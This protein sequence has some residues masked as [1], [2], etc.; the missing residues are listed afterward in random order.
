MAS[1]SLNRVSTLVESQLP[2]FIRSD[3]PVFVEF[4]EKYYEFLEQPGK[5]IY[6]LKRFPDNYNID[7]ARENLLNYFREKI[8][9]SF[10]E[11]SQLSTERIIKSARDFYAKKGTPESFQFL[12][13]VLYDKDLEIYFPKLQILKAS[14]GKWV[15]PQAFRLTLSAV[16]TSLNLDLIEKKKAFGSLSRATCVV[17]RAFRTL[18]KG[19]NTEIVEIYV[20]SVNRL[21]QNGEYLEIQYIDESGDPQI[22]SEKIIGAISNIRINPRRRGTRYVTGDPVVING[23]L[24]ITS[25]TRQK[26][27]ALVGNVTTGSID[28]ISILKKGYGFRAFP[29]SLVDIITANGVGANVIV[30]ALDI[31]NVISIPYCTDSIL[32]K[33]NLEIGN[34]DFD[35][36]NVILSYANTAG[37]GNSTTTVNI[38]NIAG[39]IASAVDDYYN[40]KLL[41]IISGTGAAGSP[42]SAT[43][44]DY[45]GTTKI[46]TL[47][48][49]LAIAPDATSNVTITA[50]ANTTLGTAFSYETLNLSPLLS[51][52]TL[53]GGSNFDAEPTL[54]VIAVYDSDW[55]T[56][57]GFEIISPGEF[58]TYNPSN[59]SIKFAGS[60]FSSNDG[61]YVGRR[62]FVEKHFRTIIG[63][64]GAT[65][66]AFL[67][68]PFEINITSS[69]SGSI[70]TKT[71]RL[72][73][74]PTIQ[75][76]GRIAAIEIIN[77]GTGYVAGDALSFIGTGYGAAATV[78]TVDPNGA[79]T[80][81]T[82]SDRGEGYPAAPTISLS[83]AGSRTGAVLQAVL[84]SDGEEFD[85]VTGDIGQI[86]DFTLLSR[87]S[88]YIITPNVS[89]KIYDLLLNTP[90]EGVI[91]SEDDIV[92]QGANVNITTFRATVD[93]YISSNNILRVFNYSGA[94]IVGSNLVLYKA[95]SSQT[96]LTMVSSTVGGKTYPYRVGNGKA[97][98]NAEFLNGLIRY[99]GF[100]LNTDGHLSSDKK[101][102]DDEKYHN[103]S[104]SLV[105][106]ESL[107]NYKKTIL[108]VSHPAGT[109]LLATHVIPDSY[110]VNETININTHTLILT[111]N[112]LI[113]S[114]NIAYGSNQVTNSNGTVVEY[115]DTVANVGDIIIINSANSL[116]TF[117]K[118]ITEIANNNSLNIESP[119]ILIGE[120][121]A[122]TNATNAVIEISGNT[123]IL[124][125]F[126][127]TGDRIQINV[128]GSVLTK[129]INSIS[130]NTITLN[131]N[132]G[133]TS[134]N[135]N[136][137]YLVI[138]Q[139][140]VVPYEIIKT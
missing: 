77:G 58:N 62:L 5:P 126:I 66:T 65:K 33:A 46:A 50:N 106:E 125:A 47:A 64:D 128:G 71:L 131:S 52:T 75:G 108:D 49:A 137:I 23:G 97:R 13:R 25:A 100:Y 91:I 16:N 114:C 115:F 14:D 36:D 4:L 30:S 82:I 72:D 136:L 76:M 26:A 135:T 98:A 94:P 104:Y 51:M 103:Y 3:Y 2:E 74:R 118:V 80:S 38:A 17:E 102:Q 132:T 139:F 83:T 127:D 140:N 57:Q 35:F 116:R 129:T 61:W 109:K 48:S 12:F 79:I 28:S 68:R 41:T 32:F 121:R 1:S 86:R 34:S 84:F 95:D 112:S 67:D 134:S 24:D 20:S 117:A 99:N 31:A 87:G 53:S 133:I 69:G 107:T 54:N 43:I 101:I 63:Y 73:S 21:F 6:E 120:G 119:C 56:A 39:G 113:T 55:S 11:T 44:F 123:N 93:Q 42:N 111:S 10:P 15:L 138:P 29:D 81:I 59:A 45:N 124:P 40:S 37:A 9:P 122:K 78:A 27:I 7:T 18:D 22:F 105:S 130:S 92:Y 89:L 8:L 60:S 70:L 96:N 110:A 85:V 88:D 90:P 19:T